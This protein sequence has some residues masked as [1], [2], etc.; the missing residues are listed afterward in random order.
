MKK[1]FGLRTALLIGLV[2]SV[3]G[4]FG[5]CKQNKPA[6]V[7]VAIT[8]ENVNIPSSIVSVGY[9]D[10]WATV[11]TRSEFARVTAQTGYELAGWKLNNADGED[12]S[13]SYAFTKPLTCIF[14]VLN[15]AEIS[16]TIDGDANFPE[17]LKGSIGVKK[18]TGW[19]TVKNNP[20]VQKI[21]KSKF[22][23][24]Y[25]FAL[26][27]LRNADGS[28]LTDDYQFDEDT[29][30]FAQSK[31]EG[32]A[33]PVPITIT[34]QGDAFTKLAANTKITVEAGKQWKTIQ[35]DSKIKELKFVPGHDLDYW[36]VEGETNAIAEDYLFA[37][38]T[39]IVAVTKEATI[40]VTINGDANLPADQ[41]KSFQIGKYSTWKTVQTQ[42]EIK[43]ISFNTGFIADLWKLNDQNGDF[44]QDTHEFIADTTIFVTTRDENSKPTELIGIEISSDEHGYFEGWIDVEA[45]SLWKN[46][47]NHPFFR[48]LR[49]KTG[50]GLDYWKLEGGTEP[51]SDSYV[52][53]ADTAIFAV[54]K[55]VKL[56]ITIDGDANLPAD[57]KKTITVDSGSE[58]EIIKERD[59]IKRIAFAPRFECESWKLTNAAGATLHRDYRFYKDCVI[60]VVSRK[61]SPFKTDG[62]GTIIDYKDSVPANLEIPE[63]I[64]TEVITAVG[65]NV[66][67]NTE[68]TAVQF[69]KTL[70]KIG[71]AAFFGCTKLGTLDFSNLPALALIESDA[72]FGC[73]TLTGI[74]LSVCTALKTIQDGAFKYCENLQGTISFPENIQSIGGTEGHYP[75]SD[76]GAFE[77]CTKIT[78]LDFSACKK[79]LSIG[80]AA[81]KGC[82]GIQGSLQLPNTIG[83]I[84]TKAFADCTNI[85]G[86]NLAECP[87]LQEIG[88]EAFKGCT[89]IQGKMSFP[90]NLRRIGSGIFASCT[91]ITELDFSACTS[92]SEIGTYSGLQ[93]LT[94]VQFPE[95]LQ[96]I[97]HS[98]FSGCIA[99]Q[100]VDLS[101]YKKLETIGYDAFKDCKTLKTVKFSSTLTSIEGT[102]FSGCIALET[103]DFSKCKKLETIGGFAG[104]ENLVTVLF[105]EYLKTIDNSAFKDCV[106]LETANLSV[107][108]KLTTIGN[109]AFDGC[110]ALTEA[111][112]GDCE[113]LKAIE[114]SVFAGCEKLATVTFPKNLETIGSSAF[115]GCKALTE[116]QLGDCENLKA[117]ESSV[118]AGC[119][120]LATVTFPKNLETIGSSAFNG[121]K[122][123]TEAQL[124]GCEKLKTI[125]N[126]VF[127]GCEK[128][129]TV[130]FPK[131]L[132]TIGSSAF[133]GCKALTEAQLGGCEKLKTIGNSVFA[134]CEKLATVTF[135]KNLETIGSSAF[136][137]CKALTEAKLG[138][139]EKL[140]TIGNSV[141]AGC[142]KLA[143]V[144]FPKNLETIGSS[145]FNGCKALTE[146][147]LGDCEN[148][149]FIE[150]SVFAGCEN[151]ATVTFPKSLERIEGRYYEGAFRG[152]KKLTEAKL[153]DCENLRTIGNR[154]FYGCEKL[155][156]VTFPASLEQIGSEE[157]GSW[158]GN[159]FEGCKLL[160]TVDLFVCTNLKFIGGRAFFG[161]TSATVTLPKN[162]PEDQNAIG[163]NAFGYLR[164]GEDT[165]CKKVIVPKDTIRLNVINSGWSDD[166]E[167]RVEVGS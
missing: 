106:K 10:T 151:L 102:A 154:A 57:Q 59:E 166:P 116:A 28:F 101:A 55:E 24:G 80:P 113:N 56:T 64:G 67:K 164:G 147:Q 87:Q 97:E 108:T 77:G 13:D 53:T 131:N 167:G 46:I 4:I 73:K 19:A 43:N 66:F 118:F 35:N 112:R 62:A 68:I 78:K 41:K 8:G 58:W 141:F 95:E 149:K 100:E 70:Q 23:E 88:L 17:E 138:G 143:T 29:T 30:I 121:C 161:C 145:A 123:L 96:K 91:K 107:C 22:K 162:F 153:G 5:G 93:A 158:E 98:A 18:G 65:E 49:F 159:S 99:L 32:T 48:R 127:A 140:K 76:T 16:I 26:W 39:T 27:R 79:L 74:N 12:L 137:G 37:A 9:K 52:F 119:E 33:T 38:D 160:E 7:V 82:T 61:E 92:L 81:F 85:T 86:I 136:N 146:A 71:E 83:K 139:C 60:F 163:T 84:E 11:K 21:E 25:E 135:P 156:T 89:K 132:E 130:T 105:P 40:T 134:G 54:S 114:S 45:G 34:L 50:Y 150:S 122:A 111:K 14:A 42:N 44:L 31:K 15:H 142:E 126:S 2:L 47:K 157:H 94:T 90:A 103:L 72:F 110:K 117:I 125:G 63:R 165:R 133:N 115:N 144:T 1:T 120:K 128:L 69:P 148:L 36:K 20:T 104:C 3:L 155:A 75:R 6:T 152:C 124:G 51:L 129:A 109:S